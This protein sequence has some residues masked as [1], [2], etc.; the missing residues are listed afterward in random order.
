MPGSGRKEGVP[1]VGEISSMYRPLQLAKFQ[2][3]NISH[4]FGSDHLQV[5]YSTLVPGSVIS[6]NPKLSYTQSGN[7][8]FAFDHIGEMYESCRA[9]RVGHDLETQ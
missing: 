7:A 1:K 3:Q 8:L 5:W 2:L 9:V 6:S 4:S